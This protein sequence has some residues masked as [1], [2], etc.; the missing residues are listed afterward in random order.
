MRT[1]PGLVDHRS[2]RQTWFGVAR[3]ACGGMGHV[4][5]HAMPGSAVGKAGRQKGESLDGESGSQSAVIFGI[6]SGVAS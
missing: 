5:E 3:F 4:L 6:D 1:I 2:F